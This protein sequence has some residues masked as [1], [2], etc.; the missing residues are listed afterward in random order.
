MKFLVKKFEQHFI[1]FQITHIFINTFLSILLDIYSDCTGSQSLTV[2]Y[3]DQCFAQ[4]LLSVNTKEQSNEVL[5]GLQL[6]DHSRSTK[7]AINSFSA[8]Y[9]YPYHLGKKLC[10]LF[11]ECYIMT[12]RKGNI[13]NSPF[14]IE[15]IIDSGKFQDKIT[16][17]WLQ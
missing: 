5:N 6:K 3:L 11:Q 15:I 16:R 1:T 17:G 2:L 12:F 8:L 9:C 7:A 4:C 14:T 13:Q 10:H